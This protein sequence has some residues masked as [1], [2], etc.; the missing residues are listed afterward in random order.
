MYPPWS[1]GGPHVEEKSAMLNER[2]IGDLDISKRM[3]T[4]YR[5]NFERF[6]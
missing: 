4:A 5:G 1:L 3:L 6:P 2:I